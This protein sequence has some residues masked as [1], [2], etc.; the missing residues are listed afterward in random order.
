MMAQLV[1]VRGESW[2][3]GATRDLDCFVCRGVALSKA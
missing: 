2:R 3:L 1:H